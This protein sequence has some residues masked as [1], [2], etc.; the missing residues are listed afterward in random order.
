M[1]AVWPSLIHAVTGAAVFAGSAAARQS[2]HAQAALEWANER[3]GLARDAGLTAE[4]RSV[5]ASPA[6]EGIVD[7]ADELDASLIVVGSRGL[8]G[9]RERI[10]GSTSHDFAIHAGRPVIIVPPA[11]RR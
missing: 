6:W 7:N 9:L 1:L 5:V 11:G 4:P 10:E 8:K 3:A 2:T